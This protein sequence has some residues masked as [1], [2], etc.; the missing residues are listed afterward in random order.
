MH[1]RWI[2]DTLKTPNKPA[3]CYLPVEHRGRIDAFP[4][5]AVK[6][7]QRPIANFDHPYRNV[8]S[9]AKLVNL[10]GMQDSECVMDKLESI[11]AFAVEIMDNYRIGKRTHWTCHVAHMVD[12]S[13]RSTYYL[14]YFQPTR[15]PSPM[16]WTDSRAHYC[17][18][19]LPFQMTAAAGGTNL[20]RTNAMW[21]FWWCAV[22]RW[23][24]PFHSSDYTLLFPNAANIR[25][26]CI[27]Q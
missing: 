12:R 13:D 2:C 19:L 3:K 18:C 17:A 10:Y 21:Y 23:I 22:E 14:D 24:R 8:E 27:Y 11:V 1:W 25:H 9:W 15:R 5:L 6:F 26:H 20:C 7:H 4:F 16:A